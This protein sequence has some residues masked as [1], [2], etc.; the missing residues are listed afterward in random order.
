MT[1]EQSYVCQSTHRAYVVSKIKEGGAF[2]ADQ[3]AIQIAAQNL[4]ARGLAPHA[5]QCDFLHTHTRTHNHT[6]LQNKF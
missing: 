3:S 5:P 4:C 2:P 6:A 1:T